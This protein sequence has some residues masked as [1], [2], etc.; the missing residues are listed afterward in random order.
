MG[1]IPLKMTSISQDIPSKYTDY[2]SITQLFDTCVAHY[3]DN[4]VIRY[5]IPST[6]EFKT[7]TY[8]QAY[9][10]KPIL[11]SMKKKDGSNNNNNDDERQCITVLNGNSLQLFFT[12]IATL[13]LGLVYFPLYSYDSEASIM[14][15]LEKPKTSLFVVSK[16]NH[17]K[18]PKCTEALRIYNGLDIKVYDQFNMDRLIFE[19]TDI[20]L[21][22][23]SVNNDDVVK[24]NK[25]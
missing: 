20:G 22:Q 14:H 8:S 13:K 7:L 25:Y 17:E 18:V 23:P 24:D 9:T 10:W 12:F 19:V 4:S 15:L 16:M 6:F 2:N 11:Q 1:I 21:V 3:G 5:C